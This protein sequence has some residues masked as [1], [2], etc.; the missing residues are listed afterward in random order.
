M[1]R[2]PALATLGV[3]SFSVI[4]CGYSGYEARLE[5]TQRRL[6][7]EMVLDK[8]LYSALQAEFA[9]NNIFL[10][11]PQGMAQRLDFEL[12]QLNPGFFEID[13]SFN[14]QGDS[15]PGGPYNLHALVRRDADEPAA[16]QQG[17]EP[18]INR[19]DFRS[20][21]LAVLAEV[22]GPDIASAPTEQVNK[23]VW[24]RSDAARPISY[25][26]VAVTDL[27]N[28]LIH[29]Y[30]YQEESGNASYNV[31]LIWEFPSGE[32]PSATGNPIDLTLG[33]FA[34]GQR[35]QARFSGRP[36]SPTGGPSDDGGASLSF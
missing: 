19:G 22:Y 1:R 26:R 21:V 35:A 20:E 15:L 9:E 34:V 25:E 31:A 18:R 4:G 36:D 11:I 24:P 27:N 3:L 29:V 32:A 2:L 7:D 12:I 30:F 16:E 28:Q 8:S 33:T 14:P 5:A 17:D 10:R 6:K 23:A 13:A